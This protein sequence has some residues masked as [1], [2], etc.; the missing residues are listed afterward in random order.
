MTEYTATY[1]F[2]YALT[3]LRKGNK[4]ARQGWNGKNMW[5]RR[6]DLH[7]DAQFSVTETPEAEGTFMPFY[8]IK[9][10]DNKLHPWNASQ[11]DMD[12]TD[13]CLVK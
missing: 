10:P 4:V 7:K 9:T 3:L 5:I 12:A 1:G 6:I 13:W 2:D 8:V 11:A